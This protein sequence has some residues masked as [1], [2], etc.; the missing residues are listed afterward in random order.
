VEIDAAVASTCSKTGLTEGSHCST[1]NTILTEQKTIDMLPHTYYTTVYIATPTS[2]GKSVNTC[3]I[4]GQNN[5]TSV[6]FN[7]SSISLSKTNYIYN[8]KVKKPDVIVKDSCGNSI[9]S[10]NFT[11][12]Y[13]NGRKAV[14]TYKVTVNFKGDYS[15]S[16]TLKFNINPK[17]TKISSALAKSKGFVVK[18]KKQAVQ[19][20]GYQIRYSTKSDMSSSVS[21]SIKG[22]NKNSQSFSKLR[23]NQKYYVQIR[24][25]KTVNGKKYYSSWSSKK[26]VNT[27]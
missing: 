25:Y 2:E 15:G 5:T 17:G 19:T 22:K 18:W 26:V 10:N 23:S 11:I 12:S 7:A 20:T 8:G 27:Q 13:E 3:T 16:K 6:V 14:G 4:C 21:R 1:C 9:S 24:T